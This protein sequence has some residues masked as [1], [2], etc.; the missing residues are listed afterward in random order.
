MIT[1]SPHGQTRQGRKFKYP[2]PQ[3][4][5]FVI[6]KLIDVSEDAAKRILL[7]SQKDGMTDLYNA[8]TI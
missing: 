5:W 1:P 6:G 2:R 7:K 8:A 4:T 3:E